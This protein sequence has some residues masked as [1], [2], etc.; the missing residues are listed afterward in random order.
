MGVS[1][2]SMTL[3]ILYHYVC[4]AGLC[5]HLSALLLILTL[6]VQTGHN[7]LNGPQCLGMIMIHDCNSADKQPTPPAALFQVMTSDTP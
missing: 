4:F 1:Y 2:P 5:P 7:A 3:D 6:T